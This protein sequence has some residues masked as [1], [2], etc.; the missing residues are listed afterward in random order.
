MNLSARDA[1][2]LLDLLDLIDDA[3]VTADVGILK[4]VLTRLILL[5]GAKELANGNLSL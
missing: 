1:R 2:I 3:R 4:D 5:D